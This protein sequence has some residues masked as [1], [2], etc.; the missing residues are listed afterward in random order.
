MSDDIDRLNKRLDRERGARKEAER[1]LELK[2]VELYE[3]NQSLQNL[4]NNLEQ[5]V[6]TRTAELEQALERAESATRA[7]SAFLAN[8]SH[9]I[10]TPMNAIIGLTHLLRSEISETAQV[11]K[12]D[13]VNISA[14]H[15]LGILND[16]LDLSKIEAEHLILE[17]SAVNINTTIDRVVSILGER[18]KSKNLTLITEVDPTLSELSL[19]GDPLRIVQILVNYVSNAIKFTEL[20]SVTLRVKLETPLLDRVRIRFEVIDTGVGIL[21]ENQLSIFEAFVQAET[22]TTRKHG[23]TG[24]G[25]TICRKLANM[26]QGDTGVI[27][28]P[29]QG[30]NFWF[31][32]E[33]KRGG[34]NIEATYR[35]KAPK[36]RKGARILLVED[37][38]IN[39]YVASQLLRKKGLLVEIA[40]HG[41]EAILQLQ[42]APY[43]LILMDM[44]MPVMDGLEATRQ[45]RQL[46]LGREIPIVAMTANAFN[47]DRR[48][49]QEVGMNDFIAKPVAPERLYATLARW[50]PEQGEDISSAYPSS[51]AIQPHK[52]EQLREFRRTAHIDTGEG[53]KYFGG[54]VEDYQEMLA[55]FLDKYE[56]EAKTLQTLLDANDMVSLERQAHSL[57]GIAGMLGMQTLGQL[58]LGLEQAV[59]E[60]MHACKLCA[61]IRDLEEM[62]KA[63]CMEIYLIQANTAANFEFDRSQLQELVLAFK[64]KLTEK[65]LK[66]V[67]DWQELAPLLKSVVDHEV[68]ETIGIAIKNFDFAVALSALSEIDETTL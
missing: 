10:R 52:P 31:T 21:P 50:L 38:L 34:G 20:G 30:S 39:Q 19:L 27:S 18:A 45:I 1:L 51:D 48:L 42:S 22:S 41:A 37:N 15:L 59:R 44:Q 54:Q 7:K 63:I 14:Q 32:A 61:Q 23:G 36:I 49:C 67:S 33:L 60:G 53:L 2:S 11:E 57:K 65:N 28:Q 9:E 24:L 58:S 47:E 46:D 25:L 66:A 8:M 29:G 43:D 55:M 5:Q 16:I 56:D 6:Q 17:Q 13:K 12:L 35:T 26:M 62:L 3:A 4:A 64:V 40:N 68:T